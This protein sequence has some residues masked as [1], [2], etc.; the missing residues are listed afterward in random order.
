M[1]PK[2][3]L[4]LW[5]LL[6]LAVASTP[7]AMGAAPDLVRIAILTDCKGP[8]PDGWELA[9]GGAQ[10]AFYQYAGGR[11]VNKAKPSA[12]MIGGE[13][14]GKRIKLLYGCS[15]ATPATA[16]AETRRLMEQLGAEI[17]LG[18]LS[19][20]EAVAVAQY[21][22]QHPE[23]TF[24]VGTAASQEPTLQI[25]PRNLFRYHGDGAQ[26]NA[27]LGEIV[28]RELGWRKAA[29]IV[30]DYSFGWTSA[31]GIIADFCAI[32]GKIVSRVFP[33]LNTPDYA[34]YVRAL[35]SPKDVDGYFW[36]VGGTGTGLALRA[37][38]RV[39]GPLSPTEHSGNLFLAFLFPK[40]GIRDYPGIARR[41]VGA[42][43]GGI[44]SAPGLK[45][46]QAKA[47][48]AIVARWHPN[49]PAA[50]GYAYNFYN[51]AWAAIRGLRA[52]RGRVSAALQRA[53]PRT[54]RSGYE[55]SDGGVVKL[56]GNRQAIQDQYP[57]HV[58][59]GSDGKP[60]LELVA[61]VPNV[62]QSFGGLFGKSSPA[63]S[64]T[65]PA[66]KRQR[67]PWQGKIRDV[68]NGVVTTRVLR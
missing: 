27:G 3:L 36:V 67:L 62:H 31:A 18:P 46:R 12:G 5:A 48:E 8:F 54:N 58:I 49:L 9:I 44:G 16:L 55:T 50:V 65:Q 53:M 40:T 34:P 17:M 35:P 7:S 47:Y 38:E 33:P 13:V 45:T 30:D 51:A 52:S 43:I 39:Y 11:P 6:V 25:A 10:T 57:L 42:Y 59:R 68:E 66:C 24:V 56:D 1:R 29:I 20:D 23:K 37:F 28:Y 4:V 2:V 63:P 19:G 21:A 32:G 61:M 64:Q 22:K 14:A 41:L 15:D 60:A 26:W